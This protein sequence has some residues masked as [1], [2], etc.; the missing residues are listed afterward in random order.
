MIPDMIDLIFFFP[1]P[2]SL[3][4]SLFF[5]YLFCPVVWLLS[6][7]VYMFVGICMNLREWCMMKRDSESARKIHKIYPTDHFRRLYKLIGSFFFSGLLLVWENQLHVF[8]VEIL[9]YASRTGFCPVEERHIACVHLHETTFNRL[10]V[11]CFYYSLPLSLS[12]SLSLSPL[13]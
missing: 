6:R 5:S 10:P 12:L 7:T 11:A 4:A 1:F 8:T 3:I 13:L 9:Y 2:S